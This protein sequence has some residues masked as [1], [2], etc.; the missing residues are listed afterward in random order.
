VISA[1]VASE[2]AYKQA[3][4]EIENGKMDKST[5]ARALADSE[6]D[7]NRSNAAYISL[8]VKHILRR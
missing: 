2:S 8:R 4:H 3:L 1:R 7:K 5:W 6:G